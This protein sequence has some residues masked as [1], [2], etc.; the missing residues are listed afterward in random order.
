MKNHTVT[1]SA[2]YTVTIDGVEHQLKRKYPYEN[3]DVSK[4]IN[5]LVNGCKYPDTTEFILDA[6]M[7]ITE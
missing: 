7:K 3:R 2:V 4:Q 6:V 5:Y 1:Y